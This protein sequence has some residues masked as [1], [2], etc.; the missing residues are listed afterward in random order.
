M[1]GSGGLHCRR[2]YGL[3]WY[4]TIPFKSRCGVGCG[5]STV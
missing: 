3:V 5:V 4:C 2:L 1:K